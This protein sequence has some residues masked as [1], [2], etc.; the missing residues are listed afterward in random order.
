L[1]FY[2]F[3]DNKREANTDETFEA[4]RFQEIGQTAFQLS[5]ELISA[6]MN[7]N[8]LTIDMSIN[9]EQFS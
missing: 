1:L 7:D 4:V 8:S 6:F 2:T 5:R 3:K 9:R